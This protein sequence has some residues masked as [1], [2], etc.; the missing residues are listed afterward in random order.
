MQKKP[1]DKS[2]S[3]STLDGEVAMLKMKVLAI[4]DTVNDSVNES[5]L[6]MGRQMQLLQQQLRCL[7]KAHEQAR[8]I[9]CSKAIQESSKNRLQ[10]SFQCP[11]T[12]S[13]LQLGFQGL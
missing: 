8:T 4:T 10:L 11:A 1:R 9:K 3:D 6:E 7:L 12:R 2:S 13:H 5:I